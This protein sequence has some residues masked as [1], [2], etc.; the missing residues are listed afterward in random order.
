MDLGVLVADRREHDQRHLGPLA[1]PAAELD[2]VEVGE[3]EVDDRGIGV[4]DRGDVER[5]L[6]GA[7]R[8]RLVAGVAE[9][10]PQRA[11]D[12][13]LVVADE[14]AGPRTAPRA[15]LTVLAPTAGRSNTGSETT[16]L[17]P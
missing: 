2:P 1:Q 16:K 11:Q 3:H 15:V 6:A 12:L 17:V 8:Q 13:L 4:R 7:G 9:D 5:L 10:H 14:D